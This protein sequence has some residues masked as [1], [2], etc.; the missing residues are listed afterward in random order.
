MFFDECF[1]IRKAIWHEQVIVI[2]IYNPISFGFK[3]R[4][5]TGFVQARWLF[6]LV[7]DSDLWVFGL[8]NRQDLVVPRVED[9]N[10]KILTGLTESGTKCGVDEIQATVCADENRE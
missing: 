6:L 8:V 9:D 4:N 2:Q 3:E 7:D 10:L 1:V 5:L